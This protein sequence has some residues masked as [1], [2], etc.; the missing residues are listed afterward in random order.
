MFVGLRSEVSRVLAENFR[1]LQVLHEALDQPGG[2]VA[3]ADEVARRLGENNVEVAH[4]LRMFRQNTERDMK[5]ER[6]LL[7]KRLVCPRLESTSWDASALQESY[8]HL[9]DK[10]TVPIRKVHKSRLS[11]ALTLEVGNPMEVAEEERVRWA[12]ELAEYMIEA[13]LPVAKIVEKV[14]SQVKIWGRIFGSRRAKTLRNRAMVWKKFYIWLVL[15]RARCWPEGIHDVLDYMEGR[16]ADG[17]GHTVPQGIMGA[18][19]LLE[20]VGRVEDEKK[21]SRDPTLLGAVRNMQVELQ[22]GAPPRRQARPLLIAVIIG[23]ELVVCSD[24]YKEYARVIAWVTLLMC[25]MSL[26]ADDVQW[27]DPTRMRMDSVCVRFTLLQTKTTGPGRRAVEVPAFVARDV[28]LSGQDWIGTGWDLYHSAGFLWERNYFLPAPNR[29]WSHGVKKYLGTENFNS[30]LRYVLTLTKRPIRSGGNLRGWEESGEPLLAGELSSF[31]SGHGPRHFLPTHAANVGIG[32]EQRDFLGRWEAG[33]QESN[34][35]IMSARQAVLGIQREVNRCICEGHQ[36]L[37]EGELIQE[38]KAYGEARG[39]HQRD[40]RWFHVL[41]RLPNHLYGLE[42]KFPTMVLA[43]EDDDEEG[44]IEGMDQPVPMEEPSKEEGAASS[45]EKAKH[46]IW[47]T[48]F[49]RL[50]KMAGCGTMPW[51]VGISE[52]AETIP[53]T[54]ADAWCKICFRQELDEKRTE[55]ESSTSGSSSSTDEDAEPEAEEPLT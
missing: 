18:L 6:R 36:G 16:V 52:E 47:R 2:L 14:G 38:L 21:L 1:N 8:D 49:R 54:K 51:T 26:R 31:W 34:A 55:E 43:F 29:D 7:H 17:C 24:H 19:A 30:Y 44:L 48:G 11:Q 23:L 46:W 42:T 53:K 45:S 32:K 13:E 3:L 25:W 50:H 39:I 12:N 33:A 20:T 27:V 5:R 4:E 41:R 28:G 37:T 40:G 15:T 9:L 35:Y 10:E 22:K